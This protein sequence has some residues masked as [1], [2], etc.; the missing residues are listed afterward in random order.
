MESGDVIRERKR[1]S[2][3]WSSSFRQAL[4]GLRML[5]V[6]RAK[7]ACL[8]HLPPSGLRPAEVLIMVGLG[9]VINAVI[10][11]RAQRLARS[12]VI[13]CKPLLTALSAALSP[14]LSVTPRRRTAPAGARSFSSKTQ[15]QEK[16]I[17]YK[18]SFF[19]PSEGGSFL[20]ADAS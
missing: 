1:K 3:S 9:R 6:A 20:D 16:A 13:T 15:P 18:I 4:G 17:Y 12:A 11:T 5:T 2:G 19:V 7:A 8:L 14:S 10:A